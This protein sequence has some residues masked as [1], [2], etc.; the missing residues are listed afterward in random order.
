MRKTGDNAT[1]Q[2]GKQPRY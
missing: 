1:K 2:F